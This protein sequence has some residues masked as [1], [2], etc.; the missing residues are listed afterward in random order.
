MYYNVPPSIDVSVII[1]NQ[2]LLAA[3]PIT[4]RG[5]TKLV[6]FLLDTGAPQSMIHREALRR[7]GYHDP[8]PESVS[9]QFG[10]IRAKLVLNPNTFGAG[11]QPHHVGFMS[12]LGLDVIGLVCRDLPEHLAAHFAQ[13][14]LIG[15][16]WVRQRGGGGGGV[17]WIE[18][19]PKRSNVDALRDAIKVKRTPRLDNIAADELAIYERDSSDALDSRSSLKPGIE[20]EFELPR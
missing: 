11:D 16:V 13:I 19:F 3:M 20:Y 6:L 18:A 9:I 8:L 15:P 5:Q 10:R 12:I 4:L 1:H 7:F 14:Q 2:R 17:T